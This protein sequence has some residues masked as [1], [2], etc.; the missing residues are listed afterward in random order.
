E[1]W[2]VNSGT[3]VRKAGGAQGTNFHLS[4]SECLDGQCDTV[5]TPLV[6]LQA[7]STLSLFQ[8]YDTETPIPTPYDRANVGVIDV[9]N[10]SRTT[11]VP[12]GGKLYDLAPNTPN[13]ACVT[14]NQAGWAADTDPDCDATGVAFNQSSWSSGALNPG[15][16][17]TGRKA[18]L[19]VA[20]GTDP[21]ANGY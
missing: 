11:V 7:N 15:G 10:V 6:R 4:S 19:E 20:Y 3:F 2:T 16:I 18:Q 5:R 17:F 21:G 1:G 8:R 12:N 13:G 14:L 9:D